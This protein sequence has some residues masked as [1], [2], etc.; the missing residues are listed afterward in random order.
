[1]I[2]YTQTALERFEFFGADGQTSDEVFILQGNDPLVLEERVNALG[3]QDFVAN[4]RFLAGIQIAGGGKGNVFTVMMVQSTSGAPPSLVDA[5]HHFTGDDDSTG[6]KAFFFQASSEAELQNQML[7]ANARA[8]AFVTGF[9]TPEMR[10]IEIA[11]SND[12]PEFMGMM[13]VWRG[14]QQ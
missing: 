12:G 9:A 10:G 2:Y 8:Q 5:D 14:A 6:L 11:G 4:G 3:R 13:L 7:K 1:V